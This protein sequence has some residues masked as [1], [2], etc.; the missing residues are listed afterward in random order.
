MLNITLNFVYK[1]AFDKALNEYV[2]LN[3]RATSGLVEHTAKK[4]I[5]GFNPRSP[6][7]AK[8]RGLRKTFYDQRAT[9][10]K[11][12]HE[13][14]VRKQQG[15]GT[16]RPPKKVVSKNPVKPK[17]WNQAIAW[18]ASR[19]TAWLQATMLYKQWRA[20][21]IPKN[22]KLKPSLDAKHYPTRN[23]HPPTSVDIRTKGRKPYVLWKSRVPGVLAVKFRDK[24]IRTA[25]N[26]ARRD[27]RVYI[28]RKHKQIKLRDRK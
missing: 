8:V 27:M 7:K 9:A 3:R 10:T 24:A 15:R 23:G 17:T 5:T 26:D 28:K 2:K 18:R 25:L 11:I 12:R 16:L 4:V 22:K 19:G 1:R 14:K 21:S 6:S 13:A 20:N